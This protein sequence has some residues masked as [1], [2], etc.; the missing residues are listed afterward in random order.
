M[1]N[2]KKVDS[3][4]VSLSDNIAFLR[5]VAAVYAVV[6]FREWMSAIICD[7]FTVRKDSER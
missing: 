3:G 1:L 5:S 7:T 2:V 4:A 6:C